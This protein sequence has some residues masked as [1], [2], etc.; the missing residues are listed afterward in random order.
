MQLVSMG[1]SS[2]MAVDAAARRGVG[3]LAQEFLEDEVLFEKLVLARL[4]HMT[5]VALRWKPATPRNG[6]LSSV[7]GRAAK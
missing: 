2:F 1:Q 3:F 5:A 7:L 4:V 6:D